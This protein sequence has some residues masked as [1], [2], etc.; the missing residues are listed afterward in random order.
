M[1]CYPFLLFPTEK[2]RDRKNGAVPSSSLHAY[3]KF[4]FHAWVS[5]SPPGQGLKY[6][7][8]VFVEGDPP[9]KRE[10]SISHLLFSECIRPIPE[11]PRRNLL[12]RLFFHPPLPVCKIEIPPPCE[13]AEAPAP[14]FP[15]S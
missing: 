3:E 10:G 6:L 5:N 11:L 7:L 4:G 14:R 2:A 12:T 15:L 13:K 1:V 8:F 9:T